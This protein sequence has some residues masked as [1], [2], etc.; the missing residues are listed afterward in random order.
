MGILRPKSE[1]GSVLLCVL[2]TILILS[3]IA[4]NVLFTCITRYNTASGQVRGWKE[5]IYAAEA[6]GD[7]AYAEVR[8]TVFDSAHAFTGT[9]W[10]TSGTSYSYTSATFGRDNLKASAAV[11]VFYY[12]SSGN[13]WYRIRA[14]GVAPVLGLARVTMDDRVNSGARGDSLLR[15]IDFKY[16]HFVAT[17]G[18]NGDNVGKAIVAVSPAPQIARRIELIAVPVTPFSDT[19]IRATSSFY[20][21]GSAGMVDSYNSNNGAYYFAANNPSDPHYN[22]SHSGSVALGNGNFNLG[23]DIWGNVSTNG[24]TVTAGSRIHGT[25]DN[26]VPFTI[27]PYVLPS[28]LPLPQASP[29]KISGTVTLTPSTAGS[30]SVPNYYVVSSFS[31]NLTINQVGSAQTYVDIHV[32]GDITGSIDV[33]PNVHVKV[34]FDGNVNVKARDIVNESGISGNLQYYG[35]SPTDPTTTQSISIDSPGD[36]SATFYAPSADF[37]I[38]GNP[39]VTGAIVCKTF[40]ENGNA[41]WHY[42]RALNAVGERTDYRIAS[43]VEDMR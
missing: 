2:C 9:G 42:D 14:K 4:G 30:S 28:N 7:M 40:Y 22:D 3:I 26:N 5:S 35:I 27:P 12:D 8:K 29:N 6:G 34:Y 38:K 33:K 39:D 13:P 19:A 43:Y 11:D 32:T 21:P 31:G 20:G 36:F 1:E 10:T 18:P 17:Y 24:G 37:Q 16:D 41:S 23:G 25:I 15:K